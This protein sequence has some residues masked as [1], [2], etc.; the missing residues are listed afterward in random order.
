MIAALGGGTVLWVRLPKVLHSVR[1]YEHVTSAATP[2]RPRLALT[3]DLD[4][5]DAVATGTGHK[6]RASIF[7]FNPP[8]LTRGI[9]VASGPRRNSAPQ[10]SQQEEQT[11]L[12]RGGGDSRESAS[13]NQP[14]A[15]YPGSSARI[16]VPVHGVSQVEVGAEILLRIAREFGRTTE[17]L[18]TGEDRP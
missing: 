14:F 10:P 9:A 17:W 6:V 4:K 16:D 8:A 13:P 15:P 3:R 7:G 12:E 18:L 1:S 2:G 5:H 11:V